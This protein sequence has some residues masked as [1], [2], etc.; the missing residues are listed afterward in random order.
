MLNYT[1]VPVGMLESNSY[2]LRDDATG[3]LALI[4]CGAFTK[5]VQQAIEAAGADLRYILLTHGHFDHIQG[6]AMAKE[7]YPAAQVGIGAE[8][9]GYLRGETDTYPD[10][11]SRY[12]TPVEP[13]ILLRDGDIVPLGDSVL[14]VF[15]TPGH[16]PGGVCYFCEADK[17]L[18]TG[19]TLFREE[20]G[21]ADLL[22]GCWDT[23]QATI[24][25]LYHNI[26]GDCAVLPGH[27]PSSTLEHERARN[28]WVRAT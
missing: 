12:K 5:A 16:T 19:D 4:D 7:A 24:K 25:S 11:V 17:L 8:D 9:A 27:G 14:R 6:V 10:R 20:V 2:I 21:R 28:A 18:F 3:A 1:V 13:D 23:L 22:G 15:A 26:A